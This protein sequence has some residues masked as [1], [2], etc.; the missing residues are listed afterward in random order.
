M[1]IQA[2]PSHDSSRKRRKK[3]LAVAVGYNYARDLDGQPVV[4][5]SGNS[6]KSPLDLNRVASRSSRGSRGR[7]RQQQQP[8]ATAAASNHSSIQQ[9]GTG[10]DSFDHR[11]QVAA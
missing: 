10:D 11:R 7:A 3:P 9:T 4:I 8:H 2:S 6:K 5:V 1:D